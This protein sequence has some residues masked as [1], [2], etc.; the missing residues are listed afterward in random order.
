MH[1][2]DFRYLL[3]YLVPACAAA[4]LVGRGL[5]AWLTPLFVFGLVPLLELLFPPRAATTDRPATAGTPRHW[6]FD[7]LLYLNVPLQWA[8]LLG[9]LGVLKT[10]VLSHWETAGL[11]F[12]FGICC[13]AL[14]INVAHEL[15]HRPRA[16]EQR[17]AQALLLSTLYLHFF[18]E[19]NRGHHRHVATPHDPATAR[20]RESFWRFLPRAVVGEYRSAWH[21]EHERLARQPRPGRWWQNQMLRFQGAQAALVLAVL[22]G[23]GLLPL[24]AWLGAAAVGVVLFQLV[25][26]VEHYGL[27]RRQLLTGA[28]ERVQPHH[29]WNSEHAVGRILLYELTRHSDHHYLA[30]RPYHTLRYQPASPQMPTGYPGMM[31]LAALPP[32]WFRVMD[33]RV[34]TPA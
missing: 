33:Q 6:F 2:S 13:G 18:I 30:S 25:N 24:L 1:P 22:L 31:L 19:H 23:F 21:L 17:L 5:W 8:L 9:F 10:A 12:S 27:L 29:S 11:V 32:L 14:G 26:Y 20:F 3:A 15:G 34:P 7:A 4:G 28:Y 16:G